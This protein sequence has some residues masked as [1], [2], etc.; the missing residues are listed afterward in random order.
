M[1]KKF[2]DF[3]IN[4]N[5]DET[6]PSSIEI[7]ELIDRAYKIAMDWLK[8]HLEEMYKINNGKDV[9]EILVRMGVVAFYK[10]D[11]PLSDD[12]IEEF[13]GATALYDFLDKWD[14][15]LG[16]TGGDIHITTEGTTSDY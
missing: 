2:S 12:D 13:T 5:L 16:L 8:N 9:D 3:K 1:L 7:Q 6:N 4:E 14:N 15:I 11:E 10:N